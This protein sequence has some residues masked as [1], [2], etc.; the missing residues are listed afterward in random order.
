MKVVNNRQKST[1]QFHVNIFSVIDIDGKNLILPCYFFRRIT[2][3]MI[4]Q[5]CYKL[6]IKNVFNI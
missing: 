5:I 6:N 3:K 1:M 2:V 4:S